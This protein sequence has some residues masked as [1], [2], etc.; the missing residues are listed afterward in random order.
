MDKNPKPGEIVVM[1]GAAVVLV[2][3]FFPFFGGKAGADSINAWGSGLFPVATL[4]VLCAVAA[5]VLVALVRFAEVQYPREGIVGFAYHQVLLVLTS[6]ATV[7]A[8]AYLIVA[9][10]PFARLG[11]GFWMV[12]FGAVATLVGS[13]ILTNDAKTR[14]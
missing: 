2:F 13:V 12:F 7:V 1:A 9:K 11:F 10:G 4:I 6:F 14:A 5:G 3:S 8:F